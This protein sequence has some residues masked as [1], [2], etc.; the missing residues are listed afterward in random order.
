MDV[1]DRDRWRVLSTHLDDLLDLDDEARNARLA[2]IETGDPALAADLRSLLDERRA[3]EAERFLEHALVT[4]RTPGLAG[5]TVGAY[6]LIAPIGHGGMGGVWLAER[7]D[8]R[9]ERRVAVKFLNIALAGRGEARFLREG[10]LLARLTH[11]HIARLLD[12]GVA[13]SGQP[14]LVIE[15]VDGEPIDS[16]CARRGL[17][18]RA[19]VR[20]VLDVL[21]AVA[22]AHTHLV[23]HRDIKPS[24]ILV[25][26]SGQ[27]KLLDFGIAKLLEDDEQPGLPS[28]LTREAG[29]ALTPE[30]A[31]PEQL[32][33]APITTATDIYALGVLCFVLLAGRHP[34]GDTLHSTA[35]IVKAV[36]DDEPPALSAVA[37]P[38][39]TRRQLRG[40]LDTI[41]AKALKKSPA[42]RYASATA[43]ADDFTRWLQDL[44]I[45]ARRDTAGYR[46]IKFI[47]RNTLPVTAGTLTMAAL[48]GGLFAANRERLV[49][50]RRFTE[51]RRLS[52]NVIGLDQRIRNLA[53]STEARRA[54]VADSLEYLEGLAADARPDPDL[55]LEIADGYRRI[56]RIQG[57]PTELNLGDF[58]SAE[59]SL[60]KA[61]A[62]VERVL[63]AR[64]D[65]RA[66]L[67]ESATIAHDRMIIA[68]SERRNA[69][70]RVHAA[71]A[72]ARMDAFLRR[73]DVSGAERDTFA[74]QY[75]NV[76]LAYVNMHDYAAAVPQA[77]RAVELA[78]ATPFSD[79]LGSGLSLLANIL[80]FKGDVDGAVRAI[81]EAR[82]A[83]EAAHY[84]SD[85]TKMIERYGV[86]LRQGLI[87]GEH[88]G[89]NANQPEAAAGVLQEALDL[90]KQGTLKDAHDATSRT[91][92][93]TVAR[94]LGHIVRDRDPRRALALYDL[95]L[96]EL[97]D[98][99][100]NVKATRDR[101]MLLASASYPLRALAQPVEARQRIDEAL[102]LLETT[103]DYPPGAMTFESESYLVMRADADALAGAGHVHD[104]AVAYERLLERLTA[105]AAGAATDLRVATHLSAF[106]AAQADMERRDGRADAARLAETRRL[107][108]WQAWREKLPG[109]P[110]VERQLSSFPRAFR[111]PE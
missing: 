17:D 7:S 74:G 76:A 11:P 110:F 21:A 55:S 95:G 85:T 50:Q 4:P 88:E 66:A 22:H 60:K 2:A 15:Y 62:L 77:R 25:D 105:A 58:A 70:A 86:L 79:H 101:A 19:R 34:A 18:V 108:I 8:G 64:P 83:S 73:P 40:D 100:G 48:A 84:E 75:S 99:R 29:V 59:D 54:L 98:I 6:T 10:T 20:L 68:Q 80:R 3:I 91:R 96:A 9:F 53:G 27:V 94:E 47:R 24:N 35:G 26:A 104:A 109:N 92:V 78:R 43:F 44:P 61:D 1:L 67:S 49:A 71:R 52:N 97:S 37:E 56:G 69:D 81:A 82:A 30:Y 102:A 16:Y 33:G 63:A 107:Q 111:S 57:V 41:V 23:V 51:L 103:K 32:T 38:A 39:S 46:A 14:F 65:N 45:S 13:Q 28:A 89:V 31:A 42:H 93:A 5:Q 12:A 87:L 36:V 106:Y 72:V 90:T